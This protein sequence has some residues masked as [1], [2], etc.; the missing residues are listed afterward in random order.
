MTAVKSYIFAG[1]NYL[2]SDWSKQLDFL[3]ATEEISME[4]KTHVS[5]AGN[6]SG[7]YINLKHACVNTGKI[8]I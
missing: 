8:N 7:K 3:I 2:Q 5:Y 1:Y 6:T 4:C